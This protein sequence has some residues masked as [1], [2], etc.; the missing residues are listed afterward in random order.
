MATDRTK[1]AVTSFNPEG[2][3]QGQMEYFSSCS[4]HEPEGFI[5]SQNSNV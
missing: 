1:K 3:H 5:F 2:L 4:T